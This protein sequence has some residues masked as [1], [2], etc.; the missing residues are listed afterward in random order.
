MWKME[1]NEAWELQGLWS[2]YKVEGARDRAI[3]L[4][5]HRIFFHQGCTSA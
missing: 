3:G 5:G 1:K 2:K 4:A